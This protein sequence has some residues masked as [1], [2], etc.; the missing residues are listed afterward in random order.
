MRTIVITGASDGIGAAASRQLAETGARLILVGRSPEKTSAV[1]AATGAEH[2]V[3]DFA[4]LDDVRRLAARLVT[5]SDDEFRQSIE[6]ETGIRPSWAAEAFADPVADV[7]Q[8][9]NRIRANPFIP[10]TDQVRGFVFDVATGAID[11]V[12]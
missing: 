7:K 4:R 11:E 9:I 6:A 2:Y 3:A 10:R 8:G 5:F 12:S 1:A